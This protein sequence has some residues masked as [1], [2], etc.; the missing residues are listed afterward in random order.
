MNIDVLAKSK[1]KTRLFGSLRKVL[2]GDSEV[3]DAKSVLG[4]VAFHGATAVL[5]GELGSIG[6]VSGGGTR[7]I[8]CVKEARNRCALGAGNPKVAR[9]RD[10][11]N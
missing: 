10:G 7:L 4:D 8:L 1:G 2:I 9:P 5:Y 11:R 6:L 3:T